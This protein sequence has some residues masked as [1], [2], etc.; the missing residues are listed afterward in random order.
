VTVQLRVTDT[1]KT[2]PVEYRGILPDLFKEGKGVVAQGKLEGDG[3]FRAQEVLAKH[4]ENYMP[5]EAADARTRAKA[6][7][8]GRP[9]CRGQEVIPNSATSRSSLA[10]FMAL[11]LGTLPIVGA[12][13]GR[14]RLDGAGAP[15][16]QAQ[17]VFV[18][19]A[20]GCLAG[21]VRQQRLL[22]AQ[23]RQQLQLALPLAYRIAASWGSHE[24][25]MLLWV[26]MLAAGC[27]A[28]ACFSGC[29][30][31]WWRACWA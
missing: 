26:L 19:I 8:G 27:C 11:V 24:G 22:G 7:A 21:V 13:R 20:F 29:R 14:R 4:D 10:L 28:V 2:I 31:P 18:A 23:R 25:S 12:A 6:R 5:P 1:A 3:V 30:W 17:F 9:R 15:A 16:A